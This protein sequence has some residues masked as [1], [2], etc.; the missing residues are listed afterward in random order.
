MPT[1]NMTIPGV[2]PAKKRPR[3]ARRGKFV[4]TY[5]CQESEE[6][7]V[8]WGMSAAMNGRDAIPSGIPVTLRVTFFMPIPASTSKRKRESLIWHVKT[9]DLDNLLKFLKDCGNGILWH[10]D[11]Q[12][13]EIYA[14]KIYA[15][16][17]R[18]VI[19]LEWGTVNDID[20]VVRETG[21]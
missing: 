2:M 15:D 4:T 19:V 14:G 12:V 5:N 9:P 11:S 20:T 17:P 3:F 18:T 7:K 1:I 16:N 13:C 8:R 6:G 21:I 10:D